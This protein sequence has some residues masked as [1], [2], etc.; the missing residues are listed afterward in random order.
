MKY[1][2]ETKKTI[3]QTVNDLENIITKHGFGVLHIHNLKQTMKNKGI[4]FENE[5]LIL[6]ICNPAKAKFVLA[7]DMSLN[8]ALPCRI[9][10]YED[11]GKIKIG[12]ILP[13]ALLGAL[14]DDKSLKEVAKEVEEISKAIIDEAK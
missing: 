10:V 6:E 5:C 12:T 13:T 14:S 1:I 2:V 4:D 7:T 8:M 11:D 3:T 9:S